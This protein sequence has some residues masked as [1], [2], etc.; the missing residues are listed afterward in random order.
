M[1]RDKIKQEWTNIYVKKYRN[2]E[3]WNVKTNKENFLKS[4]YAQGMLMI[5]WV[6]LPKIIK[7]DALPYTE[8]V[9]LPSYCWYS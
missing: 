9:K 7:D 8:Y 1:L 2:S 6:I 4:L 3:G 5:F